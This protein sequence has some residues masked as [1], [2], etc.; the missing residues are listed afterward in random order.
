MPG[1]GDRGG[2]D[3][4]RAAA[5]LLLVAVAA[6]GLRAGGAFSAAGS[7]EILGLS[8]RVVYWLIASADVL[9][10]PRVSPSGA[11]RASRVTPTMLPAPLTFSTTNGL[12]SFA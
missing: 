10:R 8:G 6:V 9:A 4:R 12:P 11:A 2:A 7:S 1:K 5:V 3:M